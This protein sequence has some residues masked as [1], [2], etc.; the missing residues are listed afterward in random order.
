VSRVDSQQTGSAPS[1]PANA[2]VGRP[3]PTQ[4]RQATSAALHFATA[5]GV[6][7][8]ATYVIWAYLPQ[9]LDVR[10]DI[11]GYPIHSNFN[12]NLYFWRYWLLAGFLPL[13]TLGLFVLLTKVIRR[14]DAWRRPRA[15]GPSSEAPVSQP[16]RWQAVATAIGRTLFVGAIFGLETAIAVFQK[17][18]WILAVGL[19]VTVGYTLLASLVALAAARLRGPPDGFW[20]RLALVNVLAVP[21]CFAGLYAVSRSTQVTI[22]ASGQ[23]REYSWLPAWLAVGGT[24]A[25]LA[26]AFSGVFR[27]RGAAGV[28][29]HERRLLLIVAG[30]VALL[31]FLAALPGVLGGIDMFHEGEPL[32]GAQLTDDGAFPWRDLIFIHGF[33]SDVV[34]PQVGFTLFEHSR[35]GFT[36]GASVIV[37]PLYWI[38]VYYLCAYLFHRNWLFLAGT[39]FAVVLGVFFEGHL[40]FMLLPVALLLLAALFSKPSPARAAAFTAVVFAQ[41]IVTPEA[42]IAAVA[43][44]AAV[45]LFDLCYY[46]R[47]HP[48]VRNFRRTLLCAASGAVLCI[49]WSAFLAGFGALDDF[50]FAYLTFASDHQLTGAF[51]VT[52]VS[53]RF[54]FDAAAP[55][56]LVVLAIW[57]F[58]IQILRGRSVSVADWTMGALALFVGLYYH[59]FLARP[60]FHVYQSF[61]VGIPLVYY[62]AYRLISLVEQG[63]G[64]LRPRLG[65]PTRLAVTALA[66]AV[67]V[68]EAPLSLADVVPAAPK[69]LEVTV[70][71]DAR[72]SAAGFTTFD[73]AYVDLVRDLDTIIDAYAGPE[74]AV[75]DFSN[76]PALFYYLLDRPSPTRYYHVSMA[77]R[78]RT[79]DDLVKEL[80]RTRPR[81]VVFSSY[82]TGL[83]SWDG[84]SNQVRHYRVSRY[85]LDHYRPLSAWNGFVFMGLEGVRFP[86]ASSVARRLEGK[87]KLETNDLY[88]R[89]QPCDWGYAPNFLVEGPS[90]ADTASPLR[91]R[92]SRLASLQGWAVDSR[93]KKPALR[94]LA[95]LR[96]KVVAQT[97]PFAPRVDVAAILG[98]E[99]YRNSGYKMPT[100]AVSGGSL[101]GLRVYGLTR[102]GRATELSY[103]LTVPVEAGRGTRPRSLLLDGRR[104]PVVAGA[105][106]GFVDSAS[107]PDQRLAL[108]V[109]RSTRLERYH[110]LELETASPLHENHFMVNDRFTDLDRGIFFRTLDRGKKTVRLDIGACSQWR[111]FRGR[112]IYLGADRSETFAAVRL[113]R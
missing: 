100:V 10:T 11:V 64:R 37:A 19:P 101:R 98:N 25:L 4:L 68:V 56:V 66:L 13:A 59:K 47:G 45:V 84:I 14:G 6:A 8:V 77:I 32:A 81:L 38:S 48:F 5:F 86:R 54:R 67:L 55:V 95:V 111:D 79:Q 102:S 92:M 31:L 36:A 70:P 20:D 61:G 74:G 85:L 75:F 17:S 94:V 39:Q 30:P 7:G 73:G 16:T 78:A 62:V 106:Q 71:A 49:L 99:S 87:L 112:R 26:W 76:S 83:P 90:K 57:Y 34:F 97:A 107:F 91:L 58:G 96:G 41:A 28:R 40:R 21:F 9:Q 109:P 15:R 3:P 80:A 42:G 69:R 108:D 93:A 27:A 53:N 29:V 12:S 35:W 1:E 50:V 113:Y 46:H 52:W 110:W 82:G 33:L 72:A 63:A 65:P 89:T 2:V 51:P 24:A 105:A 104:I 43:L 88:I 18:S 22:E 44:L 103:G 60:D 23:V